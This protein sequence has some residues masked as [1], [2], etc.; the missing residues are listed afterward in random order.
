MKPNRAVLCELNRR[1]RARRAAGAVSTQSLSNV[2]AQ[3]IQSVD[4]KTGELNVDFVGYPSPPGAPIGNQNRLRHGRRT[5]ELKALRTDVRTFVHE[6]L[7][8]LGKKR[9]RR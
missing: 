4:P 8:M 3:Y 9:L 1:L 7:A 2:L 5:R 6:S